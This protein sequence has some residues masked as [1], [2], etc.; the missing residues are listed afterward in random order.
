LKDKLHR[1]SLVSTSVRANNMSVDADH[2]GVGTLETDDATGHR[3]LSAP[4]FT[5][6]SER[7]ALEKFEADVLDGG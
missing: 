7:L 2:S 3:G 1:P 5:D 4:R 6:D